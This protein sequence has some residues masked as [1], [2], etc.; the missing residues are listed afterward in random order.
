M[1]N[2]TDYERGIVE[3]FYGRPWTRAARLRFI[4][5]MA[6]AGFNSYIYAPK[7][8][9]FHREK[10]REQ[11]PPAARKH[12]AAAIKKCRENDIV[13]C[14]AL[15]PGLSIE[16]SSR[17]DFLALVDKFVSIADY[18]VNCFALFLDDIPPRL[19]HRGDRKRWDSL[20]AAQAELVNELAAAVSRRAPGARL[21]FCPTEYIGVKPTPYLET[22]GREII[23]DVDIFWT[24]PL[25][26]SPRITAGDAGAI[27]RILRRKPLLWDNYPVNDYNPMKLNLGPL[28]GREPDV[29]VLLAGYYANPMNEAAASAIPLLTIARWLDSPHDYDPAA[30]LRDAT[31]APWGE[32]LDAS[33]RDLLYDFCRLHPAAFFHGES[34]TPA[35]AAIEK[36]RRGDF[37]ELKSVLEQFIELPPRMKESAALRHFYSDIRRL[38]NPAAK[39][40]GLVMEAARAAESKDGAAL[41]S[42]VKKARRILGNRKHEEIPAAVL[43]FLS[44]VAG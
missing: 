3:G 14:W 8:D 16:Y 4:D 13:F 21:V 24:G 37:D 39:F 11:Y 22:I 2:K 27:G 38:S 6:F 7:D 15:S 32:K 43:P 9:P 35:V 41:K 18:G 34:P 5:F 10:W 36:A 23:P 30:A 29:P 28:E 26:V 42:A 33:D 25:V 12:L 17:S 19:E 20:G 40:S 1:K 44:Y 31:A